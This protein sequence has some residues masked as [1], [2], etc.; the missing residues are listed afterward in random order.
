MMQE[1]LEVNS[2]RSALLVILVD[3]LKK[4]K[5]KVISESDK[6]DFFNSYSHNLLKDLVETL[7]HVYD[8]IFISLCISHLPLWASLFSSASQFLLFRMQCAGF[9]ISKSKE[10]ARFFFVKQANLHHLKIRS[11]H[12]GC[13][14]FSFRP[15]SK[16]CHTQ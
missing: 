16:L 9:Y 11:F 7:K 5:H 14:I 6:N 3:F 10:V 2:E 4:A 8:E 1:N 12:L 13:S 15:F